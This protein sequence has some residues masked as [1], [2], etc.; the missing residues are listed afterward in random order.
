MATET[1]PGRHWAVAF[2]RR[3]ADPTGLVSDDVWAG[4]KTHLLSKCHAPTLFKLPR[5]VAI[6]KDSANI[7]ATCCCI[8]LE[9]YDTEHSPAHMGFKK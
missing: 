8:I 6:L 7:W 3:I 1:K 2:N 5:P 9:S 4:V